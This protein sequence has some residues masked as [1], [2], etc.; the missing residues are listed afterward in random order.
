MLR[1]GLCLMKSTVRGFIKGRA[2]GKLTG[3]EQDV[4]INLPGCFCLLLLLTFIRKTKNAQLKNPTD[5]LHK[6]VMKPLILKGSH[7]SVDNTNESSFPSDFFGM[8]NWLSLRRLVCPWAVEKCLPCTR[9]RSIF[10]QLD[11]PLLGND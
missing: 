7:K 4:A 8:Q 5:L 2:P 9:L 6:N 10:T 1:L 11:F 3:C